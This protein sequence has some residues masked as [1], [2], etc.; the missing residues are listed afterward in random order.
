MNKTNTTISAVIFDL[1]GL[2]IDSE[3][4]QQWAWAEYA[5]RHGRTLEPGMF[6][7]MLGMR[8]VDAV[9]IAIRLLELPVTGDI[10]LR[11]RD[12]IFLAAV[13]GAILPMPG[14]VELIKDLRSRGIPLALATSGHRRYVDLALVSAGLTGLF[15]A[16]V[17]AEL[18][19]RGKPH[20]DVYLAA[21][22]LLD[23]DPRECLA[24]EDAPN[25]ILSA[26]A[27]GMWCFAVPGVTEQPLDYSAADTVLGSLGDVPAE[28]EKHGLRFG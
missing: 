28:V 6:H 13:P 5:A 7:Q 3:P 18:V 14:A 10:A 21:A 11:D 16:E 1:D 2:L 22:T 24:L 25:G 26:K 19:A 17:T 9:E 20:P 4:L 15:D 23:V 27:A 12:D 8:N